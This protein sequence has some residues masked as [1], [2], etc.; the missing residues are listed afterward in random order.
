MQSIPGRGNTIQ[1]GGVMVIILMVN[2]MGL[3]WIVKLETAILVT[4]SIFYWKVGHELQVLTDCQ[5]KQHGFDSD[6]PIHLYFFW[7]N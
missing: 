1:K 5:K 2:L 7:T 4:A 6:I 3:D